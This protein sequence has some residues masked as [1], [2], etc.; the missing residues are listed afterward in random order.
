VIPR[1]YDLVDMTCKFRQPLIM[2]PNF[3]CPKANPKYDGHRTGFLRK[4]L[5][6]KLVLDPRNDKD[7]SQCNSVDCAEGDPAHDKA[8]SCHK[9]KHCLRI[10]ICWHHRGSCGEQYGDK[11]AKMSAYGTIMADLEDKE[12]NELQREVDAKH[13]AYCVSYFK[14]QAEQTKQGP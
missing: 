8:E 10:G 2:C 14:L 13:E 1:H 7:L 3:N 4:N 11:W 6:G 12:A 9:C 5:D